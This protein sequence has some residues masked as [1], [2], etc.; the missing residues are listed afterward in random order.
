MQWEFSPDDVGR[1]EVGYGIADFRRDLAHEVAANVGA[2][3]EAQFQRVYG[4]VYDL[5]YALATGRDF[6]TFAREMA[7]D[8]LTVEFLEALIVPMRPNAVMLGAILQRKIAQRVEAGVPVTQAV[9]DVAKA[10]WRVVAATA[11]RV[12]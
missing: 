4:L 12:S 6:A 11:P 10:H 3:N 2:Q 1:G 7:F 5:C 9:D 8:P